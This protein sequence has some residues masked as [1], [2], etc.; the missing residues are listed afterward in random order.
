M[1]QQAQKRLQYTLIAHT[2][3]RCI[4]RAIGALQT[5][6]RLTYL[7]LSV[8]ATPRHGMPDVSHGISLVGCKAVHDCKG[9]GNLLQPRADPTPA[10][11]IG[12]R[13]ERVEVACQSTQHVRRAAPTPSTK[14]LRGKQL[15]ATARAMTRTQVTTATASFRQNH[16]NKRDGACH[17][18]CTFFTHESRT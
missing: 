4:N 9:L 17:Q 6:P 7:Q 5:Q 12:A 3:K 11:L 2:I 16:V 18:P 15:L 10:P 8:A 13:H 14:P 1:L